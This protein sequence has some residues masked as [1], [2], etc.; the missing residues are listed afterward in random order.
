M[1]IWTLLLDEP[2]GALNPGVKAD[3]HAPITRLWWQHQLTILM[4]NHDIKEAFRPRRPPDWSRPSGES[5][6]PAGAGGR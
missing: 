6:D 3:V 2:S 5:W 1:R 4:V